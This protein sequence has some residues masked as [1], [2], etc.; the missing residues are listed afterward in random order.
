[1]V[2]PLRL[3]QP[4]PNISPA[5]AA[6]SPVHTKHDGLIHHTA[7]HLAEMKMHEAAKGT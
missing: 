6:E 4:T 1:M 7:L 3:S 2:F 5:C